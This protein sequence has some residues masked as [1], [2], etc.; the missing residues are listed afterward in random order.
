MGCDMAVGFDCYGRSVAL[1][2]RRI[3]CIDGCAIYARWYFYRL[4]RDRQMDLDQHFA[5]H[6]ACQKEMLCLVGVGDKPGWGR[7]RM[8]QANLHVERRVQLG[9][10][11]IGGI[12]RGK[13][14][15]RD[16]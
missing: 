10:L 2:G 3:I 6:D 15:R 13:L 16:S 11:Q 9:K 8:E 7:Y 5:K 4:I 12:C 14:K 1:C